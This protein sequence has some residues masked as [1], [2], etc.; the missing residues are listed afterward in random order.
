[1]LCCRTPGPTVGARARTNREPRHRPGRFP[2]G[3]RHH[4]AIRRPSPNT[5]RP[6]RDGRPVRR[7]SG[8]GAGRPRPVAGPHQERLL[9]R[10]HVHGSGR[11]AGDRP[12]GRSDGLC[13]LRPARR[14]PGHPRDP[15][16]LPRAPGGPD[17]GA[18]GGARSRRRR[19]RH[20][21]LGDRARGPCHRSRRHGHR[22]LRRRPDAGPDRPRLGRL[23]R[24]HGEEAGPGRDRQALVPDRRSPE[25]R[26]RRRAP[27]SA[28]ATPPAL[29]ADATRYT[30]KGFDACTAP[31]PAAMAAW[32]AASPTRPSASTSAEPPGPA[33]S[34]T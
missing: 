11:L 4:H 33:A 15:P 32:R 25:R 13:P 3:E 29:P 2:Q 10:P 20:D 14:L 1:M 16:G 19:V 26:V 7:E 17:R 30:G 12:D 34:P 21:R 8:I 9:P 28:A 6:R 5:H 24:R 31:D 22:R 27:A 18:A 23:P